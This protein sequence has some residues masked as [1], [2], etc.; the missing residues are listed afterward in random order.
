MGYPLE[1]RV[2]LKSLAHYLCTESKLLM[3]NCLLYA[4]KSKVQW[5]YISFCTPRRDLW[6]WHHQVH[7]MNYKCFPHVFDKFIKERGCIDGSHQLKSINHTVPL[8]CINIERHITFSNSSI[9]FVDA[10][11]FPQYVDLQLQYFYTL[12]SWYSCGLLWFGFV[13]VLF[14]II[15]QQIFVENSNNGCMFVCLTL[16]V[17]LF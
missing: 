7:F 6:N 1:N 17:H 15:N 11:L 13:G 12:C 8:S 4:I 2:F 3:N 5:K 16:C 9:L 10:Q 14:G